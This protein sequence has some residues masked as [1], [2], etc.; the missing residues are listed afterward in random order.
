MSTQT[1]NPLTNPNE[2]EMAS[3]EEIAEAQKRLATKQKENIDKRK[4]DSDLFSENLNLINKM[5]C[6]QD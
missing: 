2:Q 6:N 4:L 3:P 5:S 1:C